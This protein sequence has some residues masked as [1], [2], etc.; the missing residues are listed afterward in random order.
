VRG[1]EDELISSGGPFPLGTS[2][3]GTS[4]CG[5]GLGGNGTLAGMMVC[6]LLSSMVISWLEPVGS[7]GWIDTGMVI[8]DDDGPGRGLLTD[9]VDAG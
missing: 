3:A 5:V 6:V 2:V 4:I 9:G 1:W 7:S 8:V